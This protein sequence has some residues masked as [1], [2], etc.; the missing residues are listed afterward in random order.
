MMLTPTALVATLALLPLR[1]LTLAEV[2]QTAQAH[3]PLI[4]QAQATTS[5]YVA[6]SLEARS[7]L[8]PQVAASVYYQRRTSN[9]A[10]GTTPAVSSTLNST[11]TRNYFYAGVTLTQPIYDFGTSWDRWKSAKATVESYRESERDMR[12]QVVLAVRQAFFT[13][14]AMHALDE[15]A[16]E[17]LGN[18]VRHLAQIQG[19]VE[20]GTRPSIDLAQ[21]KSDV[22]NAKVT[23]ITAE[24]NYETAK[25]QL[26]QAMGV[27]GTTDYNVADEILPAVDGEDQPAEKL[28]E[29]A[30]R[31]RADIASLDRQIQTQELALRSAQGSYWPSISAGM[32]FNEAGSELDKM[33][34]NW[35]ASIN[36]SWTILEGGLAWAQVNE[37]RAALSALKAKRDGLLQT[38]RLAVIQAQLAVRAAKETLVAAD[39]AL[40]NARELLRLAEGRYSTGVG[41]AIEL[42]D[43]Q[44]KLS[45]AAAQRVS[46]EYN[47]ASARAQLLAALGR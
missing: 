37:A 3:Q 10:G 8:L 11:D 15:V 7:Y 46:A 14:R 28:V 16:K 6:K 32:G 38:A 2:V 26:N 27:A 31:D 22:A 45:T 12:V 33:A 9:Y 44:T 35:N 41:N 17:T 20:V 36:L 47:L 25:A 5:A 19:F 24:N 23:L 4:T 13:A 1:V 39:E 29:L 42:G 21:A 18:Q 43:A 40:V 34:W 30:G